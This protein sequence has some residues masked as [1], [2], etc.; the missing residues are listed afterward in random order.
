MLGRSIIQRLGDPPH[1]IVSR[2]HDSWTQSLQ[3]VGVA[4]FDSRTA[5]QEAVASL[6]GQR[7]DGR[8][9]EL[10]VLSEDN[11]ISFETRQVRC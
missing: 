5:A 7:V 2:A 10:V 3:G 1:H 4:L 9:L 8:Q 6:S 11:H